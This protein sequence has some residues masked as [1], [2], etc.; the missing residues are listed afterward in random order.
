[1]NVYEL[2]G[3]RLAAPSFSLSI[4]PGVATSGYALLSKGGTVKSWRQERKDTEVLSKSLPELLV[5]MRRLVE[6]DLLR[7]RDQEGA[8]S[9][10]EAEVVMEYPHL[11]G[12]FSLGLS[13][14]ISELTAQLRAQGV[15]KVTFI[16]N[17]IPEWFMKQR[18]VSGKETVHLAR[19]L[20]PWVGTQRISVHECDALLF[21]LFKHYR[22]YNSK[23]G[24]VA[25]EPV[26]S[27][28]VLEGK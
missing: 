10:G 22:F 18:G 15:L 27:T 6:E 7:V 20:F 8:F 1:M 14:Y 28:V 3:S 25:R 17:R 13:L 4:D 12:Q 2:R 9:W 5:L 23:F 11:S 21:S 24:I 19:S 16:P 26:F